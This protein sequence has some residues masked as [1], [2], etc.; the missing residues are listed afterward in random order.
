[1]KHQERSWSSDKQHALKRCVKSSKSNL[2]SSSSW[3]VSRLGSRQQRY[4]RE[5]RKR[6]P[7]KRLTSLRYILIPLFEYDANFHRRSYHLTK[8]SIGCKP[9]HSQVL[10]RLYPCMSYFKKQLNAAWSGL[11][12]NEVM[13]GDT[14]KAIFVLNRGRRIILRVPGHCRILSTSGWGLT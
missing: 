12:F 7:I 6:S 13:A 2:T 11:E 3:R 5:I 8:I 9:H 4:G 14:P 10:L 1:M